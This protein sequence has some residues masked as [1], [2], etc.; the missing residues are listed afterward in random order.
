M[1][2]DTSLY[3]EIST[4]ILLFSVGAFLLALGLPGIGLICVSGL[5][6][7][8]SLGFRKANFPAVFKVASRGS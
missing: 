3:F 1:M 2:R 5:L 8:L 6:T 4:I 7:L